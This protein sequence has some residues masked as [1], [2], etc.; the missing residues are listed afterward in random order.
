MEVDVIV[1]TVDFESRVIVVDVTKCCKDFRNGKFLSV[2]MVDEVPRVCLVRNE[3]ITSYEDEWDDEVATPINYCPFCG[4]EIRM[5][6]TEE[7]WTKTYEAISSERNHLHEKANKTDS[8]KEQ[9]QLNLR[10][11]NLDEQMNNLLSD[12]IKEFDGYDE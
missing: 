1:R 12:D 2:R 4:E 9:K 5:K 3:H 8:I 6:V 10:C 11:R 7:D